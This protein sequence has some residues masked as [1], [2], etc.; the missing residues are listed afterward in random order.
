MVDYAGRTS[1]VS[2]AGMKAEQTNDSTT[3]AADV[4]QQLEKLSHDISELTK[5][6]AAFGNAK[7][8]EAGDRASM[9]GADMAERSNQAIEATRSSIAAME[10]DLE[11]QIR[12]RPLQAVGIAAAIGFL[13]AIVTRR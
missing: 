3:T 6:V 9:L 13:A 11:E 2:T 10:Q 5:I 12:S 8:K 1:M 7:V 4:Q